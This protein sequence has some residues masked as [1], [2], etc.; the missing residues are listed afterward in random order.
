MKDGK[1]T[2]R[3]GYKVRFVTLK[4]STLKN[5]SLP[6]CTWPKPLTCKRHQKR[7]MMRKAKFGFFACILQSSENSVL[8]PLTSRKQKRI[9]RTKPIT[10]RGNVHCDWFIL[11]RLLPTPTIWF[12]LAQKRNVSEGV[13]SGVGRNGN[14]LILLT[15]IPSRLWLRLRLQ[16]RLRR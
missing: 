2:N 14:V 16:L 9:R 10:K 5:D 13:V 3:T 4:N 1:H 11:P 12:S 8:F 7:Q 15:Q 6:N